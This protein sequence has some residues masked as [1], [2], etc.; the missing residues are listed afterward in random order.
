MTSRTTGLAAAV[1]LALAAT[2]GT[3]WS[4]LAPT[5]A[6]GVGEA[7]TLDVLD[8][9]KGLWGGASVDRVSGAALSARITPVA[10]SDDLFEIRLRVSVPAWRDATD[11]AATF[12]LHPSFEPPVVR[13][14]LRGGSTELVRRGWSAFTVGAVVERPGTP[15]IRLEL[16]LAGV[17]DAPRRFRER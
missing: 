8:P 16:D 13:T 11:V 5:R 12:H 4:R 1:A 7:A 17:S 15:A 10:G 6:H 14:E 9:Q 2:L 3:V